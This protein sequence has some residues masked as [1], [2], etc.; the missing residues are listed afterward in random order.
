MNPYEVV[1]ILFSLISCSLIVYQIVLSKRYVE[2]EGNLKVLRT[3]LITAAI[4]LTIWVFVAAFTISLK[5]TLLLIPAFICG[6]LDR[7]LAKYD[8]DQDKDLLIAK[9]FSYDVSVQNLLLKAVASK[10]RV[11]VDEASDHPV[12]I[13]GSLRFDKVEPIE[14]RKIARQGLLDEVGKFEEKYETKNGVEIVE[15]EYFKTNNNTL[16]V[17]DYVKKH[18]MINKYGLMK[19][20]NDE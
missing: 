1:S 10:Q 17:V 2:K 7:W 5:T 14:V 15:V 12:T 8:L 4:V 18:G 11:V 6:A 9:F 19:E 16:Y 13:D 20:E 3:A